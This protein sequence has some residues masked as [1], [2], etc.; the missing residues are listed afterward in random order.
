M[1]K[2]TAVG[3]RSD[4]T[5]FRGGGIRYNNL[6]IGTTQLKLDMAEGKINDDT[7]VV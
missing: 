3:D 1:D 6:R 4:T 2:L 7:K 5:V